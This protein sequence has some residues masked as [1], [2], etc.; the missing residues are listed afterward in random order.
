MAQ[1]KR[2]LGKG[3]SALI[4]GS[5]EPPSGAEEISLELIQPNPHQPR[6][7]FAP[8]AMHE[9]AE[10]IL[11]HGVIQPLIVT[12]AGGEMSGLPYRLIAGERRLIAAKMAGLK[13]VPVIIKEATPQQMLELALVENIQR[14]DL[15]P[16]EEANAYQQ[17]MEDFGLTQE[18]VAE[19][20]G[21]NRVT[22]ANAVRLL[23]LPDSIKNALASGKISE[24]HARALL[25]LENETLQQNTLQMICAK[26]LSVRQTEELVRRLQEA[27]K[28]EKPLK[29]QEAPSPQTQA[30]ETEFEQALGTRVKL[31]RSRRG[32][33][34]VIHFYSEEE[35][36]AIYHAITKKA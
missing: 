18:Q 36:H 25:A 31:F 22:V 28:R 2:G 8:E 20:V 27:G 24:G 35:L 33:K 9:L 26:A 21:K 19:K 11:L 29:R 15:N 12:R 6:Q 34:L 4:P 7:A 14:A 16:L 3:L 17:L 23:R 30:I 32:G 13:T 1:Q 10:S 5:T